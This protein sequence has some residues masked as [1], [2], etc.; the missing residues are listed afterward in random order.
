MTLLVALA[1]AFMIGQFALGIEPIRNAISRRLWAILPTNIPTISELVTMRLYNIITS[2]EYKRYMKLHGYTDDK[3]EKIYSTTK[4]WLPLADV[5]MLYRRKLISEEEF[6]ENIQALGWKPEDKKKILDVT[7]YY[8]TP[9]DII[10]FA[11]REVY[12]PE[13]VEKFGMMEDLPER[14]LEEATKAGLPSETAKHYWAAH[15]ELPSVRMGF[16]M[17]HRKIIDYD[18]LKMLM[19]ALDIMPYW[20]DKLIQLSYSPVTRVDVRRLYRLGVIDEEEVTRRYED[21][22]YSPEDAKMLTEF[23]V[24]YEKRDVEE[25]RKEMRRLTRSMVARAMREKVISEES[26]L[27]Y[28]IRLGYTEKDAKIIVNTEKARMVRQ[29]N[30][31]TL[32]YL[33]LAYRE[34]KIDYATLVAEVAKLPL[35]SLQY[36]YYMEKIQQARERNIAVPTVKDIEEFYKKGVITLEQ[37]TEMLRTKGYA[38]EHIQMYADLWTGG[39]KK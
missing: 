17:F 11:V 34:G 28:L 5:T 35:T 16:E 2:S 22:G 33:E 18:T 30:R 26:L 7:R 27:Q 24:K 13:T 21:I 39:G 3:A 23:T 14:Y 38:D 25:E 9:P 36:N 37:A 6:L 19:K 15:W 10:R 8:P 1:G 20:R 12:T 32:R 4:A 31:D 29:E